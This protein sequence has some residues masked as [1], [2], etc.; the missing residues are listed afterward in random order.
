MSRKSA[1]FSTLATVVVF[2]VVSCLSGLALAQLP[3]Q[4]T[5]KILE[6]DASARVAS[7]VDSIP[8]GK[9]QLRP[10]PPC[11][12][13]QSETRSQLCP[14]LG[15]CDKPGCEDCKEACPG[16][17]AAKDTLTRLPR[18]VALSPRT[19]SESQPQNRGFVQN[20]HV[21]PPSYKVCSELAQ[22][23][24]NCLADS[25]ID[26]ESRRQILESS[27]KLLV[28]NAELEA[29]AE[30]ARMKLEHERE[31]SVMRGNLLQL[32]SQMAATGEIKSWMGPIYTNQ[33]QTQQQMSNLMTNLQLI[34]RTLRLL[35]KE[36]ESSYRMQANQPLPARLV[37]QTQQP[38]P[39]RWSQLPSHS[40]SPRTPVDDHTTGNQQPR[41]SGSATWPSTTRMSPPPRLTDAEV[42]REQLNSH[43]RQLQVEL[44][45][46]QSQSIQ[47]VGWNQ[48]V[49]VDNPLKPRPQS[50][51]QLLTPKRNN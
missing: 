49:P 51:S 48:V 4:L 9:A 19:H 34:N 13:T 29:Q 46:T 18:L 14:K 11:R 21:L 8:P 26:P 33:N 25:N 23:M 12:A 40:Q 3:A 22:T 44:N 30:V 28:R 50:S 15:D 16:C 39:E 31:M 7:M 36:K 17:S 41:S 43:L 37:P 47:P 24:A 32:Q 35:E 45:R 42:R 38:R 20:M 1:S 27:M 2:S 5:A 6:G 10:A